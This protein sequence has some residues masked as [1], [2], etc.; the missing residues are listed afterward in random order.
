MK[1]NFT[2]SIEVYGEWPGLYAVTHHMRSP[3]LNIIYI[4]FEFFLLFE[5]QFEFDF[6]SKSN[7]IYRE[8]ERCRET[9]IHQTFL[10]NQSIN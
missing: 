6:D 1:K 9:K 5:F 2:H 4:F 7:T 10:G 3:K 8:K